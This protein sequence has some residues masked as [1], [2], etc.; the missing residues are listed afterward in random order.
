[1]TNLEEFTLGT[2][3]NRSD[4]DGDGMPDGWEVVHGLDPLDSSD[5]TDDADGDGLA[6]AEEYQ[7]GTDPNDADTD[8]DGY[9][10]GVEVEV[11]TDPTD[12]GDTP[13]AATSG[14]MSI[15]SVFST[16]TGVDITYEVTDAD[17]LPAVLE[18][19]ANPNLLDPNGW[20]L[21]PGV[22]LVVPTVP[23]SGGTSL[24]LPGTGHYYYY[25][26]QSK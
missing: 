15:I 5:A 16:S 17:P 1:M 20:V 22:Q 19:Y 11:G 13:S 25:R 18:F 23:L 24:P 26:I 4:T 8:G 12:S 3:P 7:Y 21:I 14:T 2:D 6:N 10:D 9:L